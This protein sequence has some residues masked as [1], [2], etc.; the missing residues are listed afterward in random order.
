MVCAHLYNV[1]VITKNDF[2]DHL[3]DLVLS[4]PVGS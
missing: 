3:N 4:S 1:L 2:T